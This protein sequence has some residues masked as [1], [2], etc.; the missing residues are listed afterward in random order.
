M[1][2]EL[3]ELKNSPEKR[4]EFDFNEYIAELDNNEDVIGHI[5]VELKPYGIRVKG[6][7]ST[8]VQLI[9]DRCLQSF[10]NYIKINVNEDFLFGS[11]IPD[12]TKEYELQNNEFVNDLNDET[13]LDLTEIVYQS[14]ILEQPTQNLC[15]DDCQGTGAPEVFKEEEYLDPRLQQFKN[16][17][18]LQK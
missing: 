17:S 12:G 1:L 2:V 7:V 15:S 8:N 10:E 16:L 14:I 11:L 9:C 5:S 18:E 6:E 3:E 4:L 13:S